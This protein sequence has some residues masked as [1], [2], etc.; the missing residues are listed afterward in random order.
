MRRYTRRTCLRSVAAGV[1]GTGIASSSSNSPAR[2]VHAQS[3]GFERFVRGDHQ[4]VIEAVAET[5]AGL[6][7]AGTAFDGPT[8]H[9]RDAGGDVLVARIQPGDGAIEPVVVSVD[10]QIRVADVAAVDG[11]F[12]VV[13]S[14]MEDNRTTTELVAYEFDGLDAV[15]PVIRTPNHPDHNPP[16]FLEARYLDNRLVT[17]WNV[18][19]RSHTFALVIEICDLDGNRIARASHSMFEYDSA[20]VE[21]GSLW[22]TVTD[23]EAGTYQLRRIDLE[24]AHL[25]EE[26]DVRP[27]RESARIVGFTPTED[28]YFGV[29]RDDGAWA[30]TFYD[31]QLEPRTSTIEFEH[32]LDAP[33]PNVAVNEAIGLEHGAIVQLIEIPSDWERR[34]FTNWIGRFTREDGLAWQRTLGDGETNWLGVDLHPGEGDAY[35]LVGSHRRYDGWVLGATGP[36]DHSLAGGST[37]PSESERVVTVTGDSAVTPAGTPVEK[38]APSTRSLETQARTP[39]NGSAPADATPSGDPSSATGDGPVWAL[40]A[41]ALA[42]GVGLGASRWLRRRRDDRR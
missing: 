7:A 29:T 9:D 30:G 37:P 24:T 33:Q 42:A 38:P 13:G 40:G 36:P 26:A 34:P 25:V 35:Y 10:E 20:F 12:V 19:P 41:G 32:R 14:V 21:D 31:G 22:L 15:S 4:V 8:L 2:A 27:E 5:S 6:V 17:Y 28:G 16:E 23:Y 11:G 39:G 3:G 1:A 18:Q